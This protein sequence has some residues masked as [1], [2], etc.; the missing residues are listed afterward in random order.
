AI[1][2]H[3]VA[4]DIGEDG[5]S[6][7]GGQGD[8]GR[9]AIGRC[10]EAVGVI[11]REAAEGLAGRDAI[12]LLDGDGDLMHRTDRVGRGQ[13]AELDTGV[14]IDLVGI[15]ALGQ[16][17]TAVGLAGE[18]DAVHFEGGAGVHVHFASCG[19][20]DVAGGCAAPLHYALPIFAID[21][22]RVAVDIGE[23]G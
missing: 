9:G 6:G 2:G 19:G 13:R 22:H 10:A 16:I 17:A 1:D 12:V 18:R 20:L 14:G 11:A 23:D 8:G 15:F 21:G 5:T 4:V 3:R 7:V